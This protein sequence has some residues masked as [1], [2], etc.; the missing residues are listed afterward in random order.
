[1]ADAER[2]KVAKRNGESL[3]ARAYLDGADL[4]GPRAPRRR[5][6]A[7]VAVAIVALGVL[8]VYS[9]ASPKTQ[10]TAAGT[11]VP[12]TSA[13]PSSGV[14]DAVLPPLSTA[15]EPVPSAPSTPVRVPVTVLNATRVTG[16]AGRIAGVLQAGGWE[17]PATGTYTGGDVAVTTVFFTEGDETQRQAA[18]QL[19]DQFPQL[20]GPAPRF[21]EVP[22]QPTPGLVVVAGG[23]WQP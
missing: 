17:A 4:D 19:V 13:A 10:P 22:D 3:S 2:R 15:P 16:L 20:T 1:V 11:P 8:G 23:E 18:V 12:T 6:M 21:F 5:V 7:L 9:F 14:Q